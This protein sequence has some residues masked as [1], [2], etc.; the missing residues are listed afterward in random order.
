MTQELHPRERFIVKLFC[1]AVAH[2]KP[3]ASALCQRSRRRQGGCKVNDTFCWRI[4]MKMDGWMFWESF[5]LCIVIRRKVISVKVGL[6]L[7]LCCL[8]LILISCY[9]NTFVFQDKKIWLVFSFILNENGREI[10]GGWNVKKTSF[11][12]IQQPGTFSFKKS[13]LFRCP[14]TH[15]STSITG[16][17]AVCTQFEFCLKIIKGHKVYFKGSS[18][19]LM[20]KLSF[21]VNMF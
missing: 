15:F 8:D 1:L 5:P 3:P 4:K 13:F 6:W 12:R 17:W 19:S 18:L 10:W 21:R 7:I 20:N 11:T 16:L 9:S 2:I 14:C